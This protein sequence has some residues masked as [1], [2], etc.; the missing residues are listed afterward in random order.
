MGSTPY[1]GLYGGGAVRKGS[2]FQAGGIAEGRGFTIKLKYTKR[3][4]KLSCRY[5]KVLSKYLEQTYRMAGS[6][7]CFKT[8]LK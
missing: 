3:L 7:K 5:Y 2:L 8:F 1:N 4:G 6:S